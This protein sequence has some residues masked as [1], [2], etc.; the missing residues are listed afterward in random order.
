MSDGLGAAAG[1]EFTL[2][3][4][5]AVVSCLCRLHNFLIDAEEDSV[6]RYHSEEDEWALAVG[7]AVPLDD[8][9]GVPRLIS[10]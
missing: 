4:I 6:P 2:S 7:G 3:K 10:K 1:R 5:M 8:R 9:S